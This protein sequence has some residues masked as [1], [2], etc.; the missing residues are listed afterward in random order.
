MGKTPQIALL[1]DTNA[2]AGTERHMLELACGLKARN[3]SVSITCPGHS[4]LAEMAAK[5]TIS[6]ISIAQ[7]SVSSLSTI[8][9]LRSLLRNRE[10]DVIHAHNGRTALV[11]TL[12][13]ELAGRGGVVTTQHFLA[14]A[15]TSRR[16]PMARLSKLVHRW[17]LAHTDQIIAVSE[18]ARQAMIERGE[19]VEKVIVVSNGISPQDAHALMPADQIRVKL[20]MDRHAPL[21][22]CAARLEQEKN[23]ETLIRAMKQVCRVHSSAQCVVAGEG[24]LRE[25]LQREIVATGLKTKMQLLGFRTDVSALINAADVFVLPSSAEPFGLVLLEAMALRKPIVAIRAGGPAEI[26]LDLKT[27]LLTPPNDHHAFGEA[28]CEVLSSATLRQR[29]GAQGYQRFQE[30]YTAERM[31]EAT[32]AVYQNVFKDMEAAS[33]VRFTRA[34][35]E[36]SGTERN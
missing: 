14:P 28:I 21:I 34:V 3:M 32:G 12:A 31:A 11:A 2:F 36:V 33:H 17:I 1:I 24:A 8:L 27:G 16:G 22:V 23:I 25:I 35:L 29:M 15:R 9:K 30:L 5:E 19:P 10:L 7:H 26:V 6:T 18:A 13:A 20:G 4:P